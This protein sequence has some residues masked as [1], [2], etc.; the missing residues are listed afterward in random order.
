MNNVEEK[1][2]TEVCFSCGESLPSGESE[3]TGDHLLCNGCE[4]T[5]DHGLSHY[6]MQQYY[7][8]YAD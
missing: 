1:S 4:S 7:F 2:K 6:Y 5:T 3:R 8:R